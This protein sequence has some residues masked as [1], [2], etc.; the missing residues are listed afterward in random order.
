M[1][2]WLTSD[3]HFGHPLL[4][5]L[6]GFYND[7][8][9]GRNAAAMRASG[10]TPSQIREWAMQSHVSMKEIADCDAH[11]KFIIDSINS[12][13]SPSDELWHLG[14]VAFRCSEQHMLD[15]MSELNI[16]IQNRHLI[17]GNHDKCFRGDTRGKPS[18]F[19][20]LYLQM[21]A[22]VD[23][24]IVIDTADAHG[25]LLLCHFPWLDSMERG[26]HVRERLLPY[27]PDRR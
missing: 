13:V 23:E 5:A 25:K 3:T 8:A 2:V 4:A 16:P 19:F 9:N 10:M 20:P 1:T 17:I 26:E 6:R 12:C 15:C 7:S 24:R 22:T 11:D 27:A 21:F 18:D 14:D